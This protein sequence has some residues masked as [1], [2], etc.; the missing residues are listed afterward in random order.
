MDGVASN[1][2]EHRE[3]LCCIENADSVSPRPE[4]A[5]NCSVRERGDQ[6]RS[7]KVERSAR[8]NTKKSKGNTAEGGRKWMREVKDV[9]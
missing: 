5:K 4:E 7:R 2:Y 8:N 3:M 1:V 9:I 6:H